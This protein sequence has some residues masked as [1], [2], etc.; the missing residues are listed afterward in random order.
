MKIDTDKIDIK[1]TEKEIYPV[2]HHDQYELVINTMSGDGAD[3]DNIILYY[4]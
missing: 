2:I 4:I 1:I 3:Y